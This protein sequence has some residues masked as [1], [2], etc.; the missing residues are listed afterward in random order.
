MLNYFAPDIPDS[1]NWKV[2]LSQFE[3]LSPYIYGLYG[4][5]SKTN[6]DAG[7]IMRKILSSYNVHLQVPKKLTFDKPIKL[8]ET[9][10]GDLGLT[11]PLVNTFILLIFTSYTINIKNGNLSAILHDGYL[12]D[13]ICLIIKNA[14]R[15]YI[16]VAILYSFK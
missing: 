14:M 1:P 16:L 15:K 13:Q 3:S 8:K 4:K 12:H 9:V 7:E 2:F 6:G 11:V 10:I 5:D